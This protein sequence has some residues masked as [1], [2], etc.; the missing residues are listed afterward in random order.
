ME[1]RAIKIFA[2]KSK[3]IFLKVIPGHFATSHSHINLYIDLT[4]AKTRLTEASETA[5]VLAMQY[6]NT[7]VIDTIICLEG[8]QV[9]GAFLAA[10]LTK[11]GIRSMNAHQSISIIAPE[12]NTNAQM[13]FQENLQ[14]LVYGKKVL[15]LVG[16]ATTGDT[17]RKNL[18][19][20]RYYG[21]EINGISAV[22]SA[23]ESI[24]GMPVHSVFKTKDL[25]D[26]KSFDINSC[27]MCGSKQKLDAIVNGYGYMKL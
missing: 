2:P 5:R 21:G 10:E 14:P 20:I 3:K 23:V 12:F 24:E 25:P 18:D 4:A 19:G 22:F 13:I 26:Y 1:S 7:V 15:L 27:P 6:V 16:S 8:C 11:A 17:I 9:I